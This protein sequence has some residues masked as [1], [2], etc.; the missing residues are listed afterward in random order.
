MK[1]MQVTNKEEWEVANKRLYEIYRSEK[2]G[3]DYQEFIDLSE[4][5]SDY[6]DKTSV[7]LV[8]ITAKD[9]VEFKADQQKGNDVVG[10]E[11]EYFTVDF[12]VEKSNSGYS[13]SS[14]FLVGVCSGVGNT[15]DD[16]KLNSLEAL[17]LHL[18][19]LKEDGIL[20]RS[21]GVANLDVTFS[22]IE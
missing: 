8:E 15:I 4:I 21:V 12:K 3:A 19:G 22:I 16:V 17:E 18:E 11:S 10:L 7:P 6:E 20:A 9:I 2:G 13:S 14:S 1:I 5:I